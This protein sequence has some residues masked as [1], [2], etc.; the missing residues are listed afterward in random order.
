MLESPEKII[1]LAP[2]SNDLRLGEG[3]DVLCEICS[4]RH[5]GGFGRTP[6]PEPPLDLPL[7]AL[8]SL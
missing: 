8:A 7:Y 5:P 3:L 6:P 1:K 2:V 4:L